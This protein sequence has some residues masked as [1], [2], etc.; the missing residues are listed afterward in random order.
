MYRDKN[1]RTKECHKREVK[2]L[3]QRIKEL[4]EANK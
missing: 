1:W 3:K 2:L 4:E